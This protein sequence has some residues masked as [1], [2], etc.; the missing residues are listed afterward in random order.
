MKSKN[1]LHEILKRD[2]YLCGIHMG[3]CR[4][5]ISIQEATKDYIIP[6]NIIRRFAVNYQN[7]LY[8]SMVNLQPMCRDCNGNKKSGS[9]PPETYWIEKNRCSCHTIVFEEN[10]N[11]NIKLVFTVKL[12]N[13]SIYCKIDLARIEFFD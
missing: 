3:G 13:D 12:N 4:K 6:K 7:M 5:K 8:T 2:N 11:E 10:S 1:I 9:F